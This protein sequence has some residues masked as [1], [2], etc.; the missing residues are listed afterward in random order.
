VLLF[1]TGLLRGGFLGVD[2]FFVLSG[3]L[4]TGLLLHEKTK[5]GRINLVAFWS[6]R[7]RRLLPALIVMVVGTLLLAW[8]IGTPSQQF[9]A[10]E[11]TPWVGVQGVN[12]HFIA[13]QVGYW[14]GADTHLFAHLWSIGVEWQFYMVWPLLVAIVARGQGGGWQVAVLA[15]VGA[16]ASLALMIYFFNPVDS[17][18]VYEG[19]DTRAFS[20]L[21]GA[22]VATSPV[23]RCFAGIPRLVA[24]ALG[25]L[26]IS[27]LTLSWVLTKGENAPGLF[28]GVMFMHSLGAA[29]LIGVLSTVPNGHVGRI[30]GSAIPGRLGKCSYSLYLWHW[31]IILLM[32]RD[33]FGL[34]VW[35][36][37]VIVISLAIA[38]ATL[39]TTLV[40][41]PIRYQ[42]QSWNRGNRGFIALATATI[43]AAGIW[44]IIPQP[45]L[46]AGTVNVD[47]L[48]S[49]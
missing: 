46:G 38:A 33:I 28:H 41:D 30:I 16:L 47:Q 49:Q 43:V 15:A 8:S 31:P 35:G 22:L 13:D 23:R 45:Q 39:S 5:L 4:I 26:L 9:F 17:T 7:A 27:L 21:L 36:H 12:W 3:F 10:I 19:T 6:R 40:E 20:L 29:A 14:R 11:D 18:R 37:A 42:T 25:A 48:L 32:P 1:H 2:L 44:A 34:N 24:D